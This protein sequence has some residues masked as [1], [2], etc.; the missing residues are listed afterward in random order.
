M[1]T[2]TMLGVT[3][4]CNP[5]HNVAQPQLPVRRLGAMVS[6]NWNVNWLPID[7]G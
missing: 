3:V 1:M 5:A 7:Y 2:Q 6:R 4:L